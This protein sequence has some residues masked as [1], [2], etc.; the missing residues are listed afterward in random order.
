MLPNS[1]MTICL[2]PPTVVVGVMKF[3]TDHFKKRVADLLNGKDVQAIHFTCDGTTISPQG[4]K[5]VAKAIQDEKIKVVFDAK[6]LGG[7]Y[8]KYTTTTNTLTFNS[9]SV[10]DNIEGRGA[11]VHEAAHA[12]VDSLKVST[13]IRS[14]EGAAFVAEAWYYISQGIASENAKGPKGKPFAQPPAQA[15]FD[16]AD[17]LI[18]RAKKGEKKVRVW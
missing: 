11:I 2:P 14:E 7:A 1:S 6:A 12:V 5:T 4:F 9:M 8:A 10:L 3:L 17:D 16:V 18:A 15:M 13:K